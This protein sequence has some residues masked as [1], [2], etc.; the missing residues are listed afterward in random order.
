M[1]NRR[2]LYRISEAAEALGVSK[3]SV[4]RLIAEGRLRAVRIGRSARIAAED[5][6]RFVRE[7][8]GEPD[9]TPARRRW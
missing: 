9:A 7:V 4:Y 5:L 3:A 2:L 8:T 6:E 1:Q